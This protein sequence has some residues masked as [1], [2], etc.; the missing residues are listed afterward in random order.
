MNRIPHEYLL[1]S[2]FITIALVFL[3]IFTI[4]INI[5]LLCLWLYS[6]TIYNLYAIALILS[7]SLLLLNPWYVTRVLAQ[8]QALPERAFPL[9]VIFTPPPT[10]EV[11]LSPTT[12][13]PKTKALPKHKT[14]AIPDRSQLPVFSKQVI[15]RQVAKK[16]P[17]TLRRRILPD[18][19][20][21]DDASVANNHKTTLDNNTPIFFPASQNRPFRFQSPAKHSQSLSSEPPPTHLRNTIYAKVTL[22]VFPKGPMPIAR[23]IE[24]TE[25]ISLSSDSSS[26]DSTYTNPTTTSSESSNDSFDDYVVP[27]PDDNVRRYRWDAPPARLPSRFV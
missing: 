13:P 8:R 9:P 19:P 18:T 25:V 12:T 16:T 14:V 7:R 21:S 20:S 26:S 17:P 2:I 24:A 10:P 23:P 27:E 22:P 5:S 11:Q 15:T 4:V 1:I 6:S 3:L